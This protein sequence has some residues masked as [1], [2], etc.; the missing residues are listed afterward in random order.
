MAP[1]YLAVITNSINVNSPL[2]YGTTLFGSHHQQRQCEFTITVWHHLTWQSTPTTSM[3]IHYYN[4]APP[5]LAVITNNVNVNS[6][7]QYGTTLLGSHHQQRQCESQEY[8]SMM[9]YL[10]V[11]Q[12]VLLVRPF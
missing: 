4:M 8:M 9:A 10:A 5:C 6:L 3:R 11:V 1:P 2:Q 12:V 7:L